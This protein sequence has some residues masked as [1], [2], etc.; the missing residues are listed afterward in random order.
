MQYFIKMIT[1]L[2]TTLLSMVGLISTPYDAPIDPYNGGDPCIVE[3]ETGT[4]YTYTTGMGVEIRKIA[5]YDDATVLEQKTVYFEGEDGVLGWVWAPEIHKIGDRWYIIACAVF[6]E[7]EVPR[8]TMP[9]DEEYEEGNQD[10]YR[11]G[12]VLESKTEDIMG[13]YEFKGRLAPDGLNNIDGTYLKKDGKLY[14]VCSAYL[15]TGYQCIYICEME[16]PYTLKTDENGKNNAVQLS[17]PKLYWE[18][19]G[20]SVN[21]GPAVLYHEDDVFIVYSASGYSS[22][23]YCL[24]M[25]TLTGDDVMNAKDWSK[26]LT[27]VL[28][29]QPFKNIYNAGHCSFLYREDGEIYMVYHATQTRDFNKSPRVTFIKPVVFD[30]NGK[31]TF[32]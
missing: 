27:R 9:N 18:K 15:D 24:G 11:Y 32:W 3:D 21:E 31:P 26:S 20:W 8:G 10:Y 30:E 6:D 16:N 12:F 4:Y 25:L 17:A 22:G 7:K 5:S 1:A 19:K 29:H 28:Y 23:G 14:Y 2:I 13:E